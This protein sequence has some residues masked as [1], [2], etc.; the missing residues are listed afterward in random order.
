[1]KMIQ[2]YCYVDD[3]IVTRDDL[4]ELKALKDNLAKELR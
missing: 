1:M 3:I 2:L 4:K